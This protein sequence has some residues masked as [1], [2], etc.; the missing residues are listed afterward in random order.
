MV[1]TYLAYLS[2]G[3]PI[4]VRGSLDPVRAPIYAADVVAALTKFPDFRRAYEEDGLTPAE[5]DT[6]PPTRR[7]LRQ[8]IAACH[9]LDA[10]VRD[11]MLPNP[12]A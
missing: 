6:F 12:D 5:F 10:Q 1:S 9:D 11:I 8:F 3:E 4:V 7:T 2:R